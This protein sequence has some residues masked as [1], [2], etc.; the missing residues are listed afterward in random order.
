[1]KGRIVLLFSLERLATLHEIQGQHEKAEP[2]YQRALGILEKPDRPNLPLLASVL[3][4]LAVL[5]RRTGRN[6]Q[7]KDLEKRAESLGVTVR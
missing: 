4:N 2:L 6:A 5:Y 1:M 7:A 3:T